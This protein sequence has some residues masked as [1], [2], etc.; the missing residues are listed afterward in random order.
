MSERTTVWCMIVTSHLPLRRVSRACQRSVTIA[1]AA[2]RAETSGRD[3][4]ELDERL[5]ELRLGAQRR[6][7]AARGV[8]QLALELAGPPAHL[9]DLEPARLELLSDVLVER[10]EAVAQLLDLTVD[11]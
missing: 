8:E 3:L 6:A 10:R 1:G 4:L 11:V 9:G 5:P 7:E 2:A